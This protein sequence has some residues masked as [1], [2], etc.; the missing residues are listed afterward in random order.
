MMWILLIICLWNFNIATCDSRFGSRNQYLCHCED[1]CDQ[2]GSCFG[3]SNKCVNEWFGL[4]CQYQNLAFSFSPVINPNEAERLFKENDEYKCDILNAQTPISIQWNTSTP[5]TWMRIKVNNST[6]LTTL[7]VT[8]IDE[9]MCSQVCVKQS[10]FQVNINVF[11]I[12]CDVDFK[13]TTLQIHGDIVEHLCYVHIN[14]G[15]NLALFQATSQSSTWGPLQLYGSN[16]AVD[17]LIKD[18]CNAGQCSHTLTDQGPQV[19]NITFDRSYEINKFVLFNRFDEYK[20]RLKGF[21][22]QA[23]NSDSTTTFSY[24]NHPPTGQYIYT[25]VYFGKKPVNKVVI[26]LNNNFLAINEFQAYGDCLPGWW[27]LDCIQRCNSTCNDTCNTEN[28]LCRVCIGAGDPPLCAKECPEGKYG[29]NCQW[30]CSVYCEKCSKVNGSCLL[31]PPGWVGL[32]CEKACSPDHYGQ[33]CQNECSAHCDPPNTCNSVSG[34][35]KCQPGWTNTTCNKECNDGWF[36]DY[37]LER[38]SIHC[39]STCNKTDGACSCLP[40]YVGQKCSQECPQGKYGQNCS[41][42]CSQNCFNESKCDIT[43]G[44]C[45]SCKHGYK[46]DKCDKEKCPMHCLNESCDVYSGKC[47]S[48]KSGYGGDFCDTSSNIQDISVAVGVGVGLGAAVVLLIVCVVVVVYKRRARQRKQETGDGVDNV[49][50][51]QEEDHYDKVQDT[52]SLHD[53]YDSVPN[54]LHDKEKVNERHYEIQSS[55][56]TYDQLSFDIDDTG[57]VHYEKVASPKQY[58]NISRQKYENFSIDN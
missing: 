23:F 37:C 22:L 35:C 54:K 33:S 3:A 20:D 58:E 12:A 44:D 28:G 15:R 49:A 30:Q 11:D 6:T 32:T 43:N 2:Q 25:M 57:Q 41:G 39:N 17:G 50:K 9:E 52:N 55:Q 7:S 16:F 47:L 5:F 1:Q 29:L 10:I 48:C 18:R 24:T 36:G 46:G 4:G 56:Q 31:C 21:F 45:E 38:C 8:F 19:W 34:Y 51:L 26:G 13:M 40:G 27:G 53:H 14:G 42:I